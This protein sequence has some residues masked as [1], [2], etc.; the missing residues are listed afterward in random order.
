M[1]PSPARGVGIALGTLA[2]LAVGV[3]APA[4]LLGPLPEV[5]IR[6][7]E[8][9]PA[10]P[11]AAPVT[12]LEAGASA[13]ALV[14]D[15]GEAELVA[16]SADEGPAPIGGAAKLVTVLATLD[17]LPIAEGERGPAIRI[18]PEDYTDYLRY[19]EEGSRALP[20]S[21]GESWSQ[22]DVVRAVLLA[23]SNNHADTLARWAFGNL[24]NYVVEANAWLE[25]QG[26]ET[27]RVT[28]ATGLSGDNVGT[29]TELT[30][31]AALTMAEPTLGPLLEGGGPSA[32]TDRRVP[33]VVAHLEGDGIR[34]ITRS[35]T[36]QALLS[37]VFTSELAGDAPARMVGAMTG[38][39]S[40]E[41][42]DPAVLAAVEGMQAASTPIEVIPVGASYGEAVSA[43]GDRAE[44][45][46]VAGRT[47]AAWG[48]VPEAASV[49]VTPFTTAPA[50]REV[51]E[52]T[53]RI[54]D[55]EVSSVLELAEPIT[56]PGPLWRLA[57]PAAIVGAFLAD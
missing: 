31:L 23:S 46:A 53:V 49:D 56:D 21:P 28:D 52:V 15:D 36:D 1:S 26:F 37:F 50:G 19:A 2:I 13:V 10:E 57:N 39:D 47:D 29:A 55:R 11:A 14:G 9:A 45:V 12:L 42:L 44:L 6:T 4:M 32:T 35:Y 7:A 24:E 40:Y 41:T 25:A 5:E 27:L 16:A 34:S 18:G 30:R 17:A 38:I 8:A 20:V 22:R 48:A 43:W 33:D 51:G 3:Y 54:G